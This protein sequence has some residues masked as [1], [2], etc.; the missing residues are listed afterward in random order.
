MHALRDNL[1]VRN[2]SFEI[3]LL[4]YDCQALELN[5]PLETVSFFLL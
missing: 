3:L 1:L 2:Y 5:N 4:N